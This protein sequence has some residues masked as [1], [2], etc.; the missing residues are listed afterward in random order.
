MSIHNNFAVFG[1]G[2][3]GTAAA[4]SLAASGADVLAVDKDAERVEHLAE[5][6]PLCKCADVTDP[7]VIRQ[8]GISNMDVVVIAMAEN[9]EA[10]VMAI[11]LCKEVGVPTVIAKC[12]NE[13]HKKIFQRVGADQ[14]VFP[15]AESGSRLAKNLLSAGLIDLFDLT[16]EAS[17]I[18]I[19]VKPEW[20]GKTLKELNLRRKYHV[21]VVALCTENKV[22]VSIDP[23]RPLTAQNKLIIIAQINKL[24]KLV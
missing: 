21:N 4:L 18:E 8:L 17:I 23:D 14:V 24:K 10:S 6:L 12:G 1:L 2:K 5:Q 13:M 9:L 3:Y 20:V 11:M 7:E 22:S 15:E 19:D 16:D